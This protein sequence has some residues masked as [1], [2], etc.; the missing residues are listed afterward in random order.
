MFLLWDVIRAILECLLRSGAIVWLLFI[1]V[2]IYFISVCDPLRNKGNTAGIIKWG[3]RAGSRQT[4]SG[5]K[6]LSG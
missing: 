2:P 5:L 3:E 6:A 1:S 4:I